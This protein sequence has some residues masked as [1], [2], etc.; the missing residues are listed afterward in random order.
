[1]QN[2]IVSVAW[3]VN[4]R[5]SRGEDKPWWDKVTR[6]DTFRHHESQI[7]LWKRV[8]RRPSVDRWP[9]T[10]DRVYIRAEA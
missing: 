2:V 8:L 4:L 3:E 6:C 7:R 5:L 10:A 1:M 9:R